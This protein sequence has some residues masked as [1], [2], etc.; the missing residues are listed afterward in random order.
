[1]CYRDFMAEV[2]KKEIRIGTSRERTIITAEGRFKTR[3]EIPYTIGDA[4][5]SVMIDKEGATPE[6]IEAAVREDA[7]KF[8]E[9][10]GKII[11]I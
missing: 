1:M 6:S 8:I 9:T 5:Y 11:T 10:E 2:K 4:N 7:K 3:L